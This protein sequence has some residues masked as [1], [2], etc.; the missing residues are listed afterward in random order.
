PRRAGCRHKELLMADDRFD[1]R[2]GGFRPLG[3][4]TLLFRGFQVALDWK[5][6]VLAAGGIVT[7]AFSWWLL[8]VIFGGD[9]MPVWPTDYPTETYRKGDD[10]EEKAKKKAWEAFKVDRRQWNLRY[11]AAGAGDPAEYTDTG[12]LATTPEEFAYL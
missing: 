5:K 2:E 9:K 12:D 11:E 6:L 1:A 4:W 3:T 7:M 8:A 10:T